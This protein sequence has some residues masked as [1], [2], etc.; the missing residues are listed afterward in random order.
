[1]HVRDD[2]VFASGTVYTKRIDK[3]PES[4]ENLL[5]RMI[6]ALSLEEK[7]WAAAYLAQRIDVPDL[8][9]PRT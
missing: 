1:M 9:P 5:K 3:E 6:D 2:P 8:S 4:N 7:R